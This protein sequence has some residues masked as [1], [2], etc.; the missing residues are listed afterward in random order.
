MRPAS[1]LRMLPL[2]LLGLGMALTVV[3]SSNVAGRDANEKDEAR[4]IASHLV[5]S[6]LHDSLQH[7]SVESS[8]IDHLVDQIIAVPTVAELEAVV[9]S[10]NGPDSVVTAVFVRRDREVVVRSAGDAIE[11]ADM[12]L[13]AEGLTSIGDGLWAGNLSYGIDTSSRIGAEIV[14]LFDRERLLTAVQPTNAGDVGVVRLFGLPGSDDTPTDLSAMTDYPGDVRRFEDEGPAYAVED[15]TFLGQ[16]MTVEI[17]IEG[18]AI[19]LPSSSEVVLVPLVG[20]LLTLLVAGAALLV[21]RTIDRAEFERDQAHLASDAAAARFRASFNHAPIGVV[22]L[23][24]EGHIVAA[25]RRFASQLGFAPEELE[26]TDVLDLVDGE[27]RPD[28]TDRLEELFNGEVDSNQSDRRYRSR[29]GGAVW[30]RESLSVLVSEDGSRHVLVQAE[31]I[32]D[33]RRAR[34]EL[35]RKALFDDLTGLPN[36]A[37]LIARLNRAIEG[38]RAPGEMMAV[39]FVDLDKF[40]QVNDTLGHEAGDMLLI[41]VAERLRRVC[42][43]SDTVARL[44]GD[45]FV[46]VCEGLPD[47]EAAEL[48]AER[49]AHSL[50]EPMFINDVEVP[51][52]ASIGLVVN[53]EESSPENLLRRAGQ[54][55]YRAKTSG[56]NQL[57]RF[58]IDETTRSTNGDAVYDVS[59]ED[60]AAAIRR[61][62][63]RVHYQPV[64][65]N[66]SGEIVGLEALVRWQHPSL[67]LLT[68]ASFLPLAED[69]GIVEKIDAW[70]LKQGMAALGRWVAESEAAADWFVAFNISPTNYNKRTFADTLE[71]YATKFEV[72]PSQIVL[73]RNETWFMNQTPTAVLTTRALRQAGFRIS[74]DHFGTGSSSLSEVSTLEFDILKIDRSFVRGASNHLAYVLEAMQNMADELGL[75]PIV[76]GIETED[77]LAIVTKAGIEWAQGFLLCRP[78]DE[79]ALVR[80]HLLTASVAENVSSEAG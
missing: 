6:R 50:R 63:L 26:G 55:M 5:E 20:G 47:D 33:E 11:S 69:L 42:R 60:L 52:S 62:Q 36:R 48:T 31:D 57:V 49:F 29:N 71:R 40:K 70:V 44:G 77:E 75:R 74:L 38:E 39:M 54:A 34:A 41:E 64:M 46:V 73:E 21:I 10:A 15:T 68:P 23:S 51:V 65:H 19:W 24:A 59:L 13:V 2:A 80:D 79:E 14:I 78:I 18:E 17:E 27:D 72:R 7:L 16:P 61:R 35:H 4:A 9:E 58:S 22:E 25:N 12:P 37:N 30:V 67:G 45:E 3:A 32:S 28:A 76:E 56:R 66:V 8:T 53:S 1:L 43:S